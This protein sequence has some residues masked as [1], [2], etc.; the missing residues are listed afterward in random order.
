MPP[1]RVRASARV[2]EKRLKDVPLFSGLSK[3]ERRQVGQLTDEVDLD[4]GREL[5]TE[6]D[7][8]WEFFVIE[9]GAADVQ[10]GGRSVARLGPG[11]FFGEMALLDQTTRS[12][13]IVVIEP[14]T[15]IVMTGAAFRQ[16]AREMP[17][18]GQQIHKAVAE[19]GRELSATAQ[20]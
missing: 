9:D 16:V 2:D 11:D 20:S 7:C 18:V 19:R 12:A 17:S 10:V 3:D 1:R 5:M 8:A 14:T 13:T 15:A 4:E 6:G